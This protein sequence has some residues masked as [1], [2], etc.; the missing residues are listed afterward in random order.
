[1]P[2]TIRSKSNKTGTRKNFTASSSSGS[3]QKFYQEV[4]V[5]FLEMLNTVKLYH[6]KTTSHAVHK[7]TDQLYSSLN[8]HIDSFVEVMLGKTGGRTNLTQKKSIV[9]KDLTNNEQI[10]REVN[11]YKSYLVGLNN[12]KALKSMSN[13]DLF[14]IRDEILGDLNQF[15]YLL[16]FK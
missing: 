8:E 14:N 11:G 13:T 3:L 5:E 7:A 4:T 16:T 9:L 10:K 12:N 1:M 15:L 6:W 2:K